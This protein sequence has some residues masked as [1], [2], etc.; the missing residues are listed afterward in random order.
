[1]GISTGHARRLGGGLRAPHPGRHGSLPGRHF[2]HPRC[3][4]LAGIRG[5]LRV[6]GGSGLWSGRLFRRP[7]PVE[8]RMGQAAQEA[9][10]I[11]RGLPSRLL[12]PVLG[13]LSREGIH[14]PLGPEAD[15]AETGVP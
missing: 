2:R 9:C 4:G 3:Q 14:L 15:P 10:R 11:A 8:G 1:M 6:L 7:Q 5:Q 12:P 13:F